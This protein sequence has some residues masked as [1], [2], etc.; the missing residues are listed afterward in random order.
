[1]QY[2]IQKISTIVNGISLLAAPAAVIEY[3]LVDSRKLVF[4]SVTLFFALSSE[5]RNGS[6]FVQELYERGVRNFVVNANFEVAKYSDANFIIAADTLRTLQDLAAYHR[7]QFNYPVIGITGS[8]GKTI[9]KEWLYQLLQHDYNIVR[10]PKSYNSQIGVPLS[11][12]QMNEQHNLAIFEAGI[13]Q[14]GEMDHL[15]RIINPTIGILTNIGQA[16]RE[17]FENRQL[18]TLEKMKLFYNVDKLIYAKETVAHALLPGNVEQVLLNKG[19]RFFSWSRVPEADMFITR[20]ERNGSETIVY[21][22]KNG[23]KEE[24]SITIPYLDK[25]HIDNA[26][27][28]WC[29]MICLGY[30][31]QVI[32]ERIQQLAPVEMR[33]QLK[34]AVNNCTLINDSYSNDLSSLDLALDYIKQQSAGKKTTVILSDILQSGLTAEKL[35]DAIAVK[36][37]SRN[38]NRLILIG[39]L[40]YAHRQYFAELKQTGVCTNL[41]FDFYASTGAFLKHAGMHEFKDEIIL[42]KGARVFEFE[43]ISRW[44]E[45]KVH[46]TVMEINLNALVHNLKQY[47]RYLLPATKVMAMVKAFSYGSGG[48]EVANV[49]QFHKVDYLAVAYADEG[50]ELRKGG[51]NMPIMVMNPEAATFDSLIQYHL[52]PE[53]YSFNILST[54]DDYLESQGI[55]AFPVHLKIDT[56][57]HRLGFEPEQVDELAALLLKKR[58]LIVK[59]VF[60]HLVASEDPGLDVFTQQQ[61]AIFMLTCKELQAKIGYPFLKHIS[62][63][64]AIFRHTDFQLDMVRLGIGLYGIDS[65]AERQLELQPVAMLTSTIAQIRKVKAGESVGYNRR[66]VLK[67]D[68][69]IATIRIGYADGYSRSLSN[70]VGSMY[71]NGHLAPVIGN[72]CMDMTMVNITGIPNVKEGDKVE[73]FGTN[74]PVE[75]VARWRNTNAYEVMTGVSQRVK[76]VYYEE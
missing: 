16:H 70:G 45:E 36:V 22:L 5:R 52:E 38:I 64:A 23:L 13:S 15:Q 7:R 47:Q 48:A 11:V 27:T 76:R 37:N 1:M 51:I 31:Q 71:I 56:G 69:L 17:G 42:L 55:T 59:S 46:Q 73:I 24:I 21:A 40:L 65:S 49:L 26:I 2:T 58:R 9:V 44:L 74:L 29:V 3:L 72:V 67:E 54:F 20:E 39:P 75:D 66:G 61:H 50:V 57:M 60:S 35:C 6:N 4:P 53:L 28:C 41:D 19:V 8:N 33:M 18:K 25:I 63:S 68:S 34:K 14:P 30:E 32:Q 43:R 12:W 62:N 10:S